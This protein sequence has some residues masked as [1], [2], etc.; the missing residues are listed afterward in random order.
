VGRREYG[1]ERN[2]GVNEL[3]GTQYPQ[4]ADVGVF[5]VHMV[6]EDDDLQNIGMYRFAGTGD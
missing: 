4:A 5:S 1:Q 3:F 6:C 2:M